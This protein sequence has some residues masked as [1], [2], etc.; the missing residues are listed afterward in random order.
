MD[1]EMTSRGSQ[2]RVPFQAAPVTRALTAT[3]MSDSSDGVGASFPRRFACR[4]SA[5]AGAQLCGVAYKE[6]YNA[7]YDHCMGED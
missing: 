1:N 6:C 5:G 3:T 4:L 2:L 7:L